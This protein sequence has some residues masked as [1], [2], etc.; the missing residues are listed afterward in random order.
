LCLWYVHDP[1]ELY[2]PDPPELYVV[3]PPE[4]HVYDPPDL[5]I[6]L[7]IQNIWWKI[8]LLN[9]VK[10]WNTLKKPKY[11]ILYIF[12]FINRTTSMPQ[13]SKAVF[14]LQQQICWG[15][16]LT[17][18]DLLQCCGPFLLCQIKRTPDVP[19]SSSAFL[20]VTDVYGPE[21]V[22]PRTEYKVVEPSYSLGPYS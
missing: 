10:K 13:L 7:F 16:S 2:I 3:S 14:W 9:F 6:L 12:Y 21:G 20:Y 4:V 5:Y 18:W 1:P 11:N 8:I 22:G 15:S 17:P 19:M